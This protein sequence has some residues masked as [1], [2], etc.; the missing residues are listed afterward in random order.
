MPFTFNGCGTSY[1]GRRYPAE[2]GS[3]VTTSW[4]MG[5]WIP[6]VPLGSYRVRP[7]GKETNA[8]LLHSQNCQTV[9]VPLCWPQV[10]NGYMF[11]VPILA[12][13]VYFSGSD[14]QKWGGKTY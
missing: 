2:D 11:T 3:Y 10:Q 8:V 5:L 9:R 6:L 13:I 1:Y 12:L 14:I 7:T 4:V